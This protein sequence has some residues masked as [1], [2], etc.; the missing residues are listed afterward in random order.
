[1]QV[2]E[3]IKYEA[4]YDTVKQSG[5][6]YDK[7]VAKAYSFI[8]EDNKKKRSG[9]NATAPPPEPKSAAAVGQVVAK[10]FS[11]TISAV[12]NKKAAGTDKLPVC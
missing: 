5:A 4:L 11:A 8:L 2:K 3:V 7:A 10:K 6:A 1:M 9:L 12:T